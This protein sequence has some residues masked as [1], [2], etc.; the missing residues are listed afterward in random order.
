M[1]AELPEQAHAAIADL[2]QTIDGGAILTGFTLCAEIVGT[3]GKRALWMLTP[4]DQRAWD[5]LG[6]LTYALQVEQAGTVG[7]ELA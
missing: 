6:Y 7:D 3:D 1:S 2:I 4:P 5:T